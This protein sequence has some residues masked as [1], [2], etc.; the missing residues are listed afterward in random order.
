MDALRE[1][2]EE[3]EIARRNGE[4]EPEKVAGSRLRARETLAKRCAIYMA[5]AAEELGNPPP[6]ESYVTGLFWEEIKD[7]ERGAESE[8]PWAR[9]IVN[10]VKEIE[11]KREAQDVWSE[12]SSATAGHP[13]PPSGL[14]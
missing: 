4:A 3:V 13:L 12:W 7:M 11:R 14:G 9:K 8:Q 1:S 10:E 5:C 6:D 2:R